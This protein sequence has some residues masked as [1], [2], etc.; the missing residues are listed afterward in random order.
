VFARNAECEQK[1]PKHE[2]GNKSGPDST[3][4]CRADLIVAGPDGRH[5]YAAEREWDSDRLCRRD[6]LASG[7]ADQYRDNCSERSNWSNDADESD[8]HSAVKSSKAEG[9]SYPREH[10]PGKRG[11]IAR[12]ALIDHHCHE[13]DG[14]TKCLREDEQGPQRHCSRAVPS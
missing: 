11:R 13:K 7:N 4:N 14:E 9:P 12:P 3:L 2:C 8:A 5:D 10:S 1:D 6:V